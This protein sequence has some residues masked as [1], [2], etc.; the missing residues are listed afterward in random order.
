VVARFETI[1]L[2]LWVALVSRSQIK[3]IPPSWIYL[4]VD[5]SWFCCWCWGLLLL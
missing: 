2:L 3:V 5:K 1:V 4:F